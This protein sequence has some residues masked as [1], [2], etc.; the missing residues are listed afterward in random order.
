MVNIPKAKKDI[1]ER[2]A[3]VSSIKGYIEPDLWLSVQK[4][5]D[6]NKD[7]FP[8]LGKTHNA[9]L[10]GKLRCGKCKEYMLVVHGRVSKATGEK[11]FFI[12]AH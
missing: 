3:A 8:R 7:T 6:K 9:L 12:I 4:Q 2:F 5:F 1:S 11:L 10:A